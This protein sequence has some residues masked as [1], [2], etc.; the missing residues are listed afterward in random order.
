MKPITAISIF[1]CLMLPSFFLSYGNYSV[2]R[3]RIIDDVNQ[4]L[5]KTIMKR[6]FGISILCNKFAFVNN[7]DIH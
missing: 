3:E 1:F 2:T 7:I 4:A 6:E 5:A